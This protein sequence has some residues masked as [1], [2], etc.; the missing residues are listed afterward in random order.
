MRRAE[1][2]EKELNNYLNWIQVAEEVILNE[3]K[4]TDEE[5]M[6]IIEA[7]RRAAARRM[8][9]LKDGDKKDKKGRAKKAALLEK[10]NEDG[11]DGGDDDDLDPE[12]IRRNS[13][14]YGGLDAAGLPPG[15]QRNR[16]IPQIFS[17]FKRS[18]AEKRFRLKL[19]RLVK[20]EY[21]FWTVIVLVF[22]NTFCLAVEHY[23]QPE[24]LTKVL[25]Y[26]EF[27]FLSLFI[28]ETV[29]P[30]YAVGPRIFFQS[31]F[32]TFDT[33]VIFGSLF[34]VIWGE[35]EPQDSF[36]FSVLRA[37]RL[38]RIFKF[39]RHWSSLRNLVI[40]LMNSMRSIVSLLFLLFLF[41]L[42]FALLGMQ[43]FGGKW[44]F[45]DGRPAANFDTFPIAMLTV[46]QILTGEDWNEVLYHG[47]KS[48]GGV[49]GGG[50]L[51]SVYFVVLVLFGN[52]KLRHF[53]TLIFTPS[54]FSIDTLLNVFLAIAVDN[55]GNARELTALEEAQKAA[56]EAVSLLLSGPIFLLIKDS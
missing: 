16:R 10:E 37:L 38:L 13:S 54:S 53:M 22:L 31:T 15:M 52:C 27:V 33:L 42:I 25:Y 2:I 26:A 48:M 30:M 12:G 55:L 24:W 20:T 56:E 21:W 46:F 29:L 44:N 39:T 36:G 51:F 6:R 28:L 9:Q 40:S 50:M 3:D 4:T 45:P 14:N 43:V 49:E 41:I 1:Q 32:R 19:R 47:I 7:R 8:K 18:K 34:E 23:N 5:K 17:C 35:I 11:G